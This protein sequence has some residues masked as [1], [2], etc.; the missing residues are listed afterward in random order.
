MSW[1]EKIETNL[2]ITTGD[3]KE[4]RPK[5]LNAQ[6][7]LEYNIAEFEFPNIDGTL[8]SR[9]TPKGRRFPI[10]IY[11]DGEDHLDIAKAFEVSAN[12]QRAW[13]IAHPFYDQILVHPV[14]LNVDNTA[15]NVSKIT[16]TLIETITDDLP[17]ATVLPEDKIE[18]D[19]EAAD[20]ALAE[21]FVAGNPAP[22]S[23]DI[24]DM[25]ANTASLY[26]EGSAAASN[27]LDAEA[28][29][30]AFNE[31]NSAILSATSEPLAAIR[32]MQT[33][34]NAPALFEISVQNRLTTLANQFEKLRDSLETI[35]DNAGKY[36]F[37]NNGATLIGA[38]ALA[39]SHPHE[40]DFT[41]RAQVLGVIETITGS[42]N[43]FLEDLEGLQTENGGAPDSFIPGQ[44]GMYALG[45]LVDFT[46]A[47]LFV[48]AIGAKQ[49]RVIYLEDDSNVVVLTHRFYGLD[50]EDE[51]IRTFIEQNEIGYN[52]LLQVRKGRRIIYYI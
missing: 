19:K 9:G 18:E 15:Y 27:T 49:E 7:A 22:D 43:Q 3:G 30:N 46:V 29:F 32:A 14:T 33:V 48:I 1:L 4:Y 11:F 36:L 31:A 8:V 28:Y 38:M 25:T 12:D 2:I 17:K 44:S 21:G 45:S 34:I 42:Y 40:G 23:S 35:V 24:N 16:G 10:E 13:T 37:E 50:S 51:N 47:N 39:A 6:K 20:V 5:W 52:E 26:N 41:S